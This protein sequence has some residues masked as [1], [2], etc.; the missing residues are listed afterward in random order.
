MSRIAKVKKCFDNREQISF[1]NQQYIN[2]VEH[3]FQKALEQDLQEGDISQVPA[4][5][6]KKETKADIIACTRGIVAGLEEIIHILNKN[7]LVVNSYFNDGN[8]IDNHEVLLSINGKISTILALE[9]TILNFLQRLCGIATQTKK[10]ADKI[11]HTDTYVIGTRKTIWGMWDK[12]A[13]QCGGGLSH[14]LGL[15]DAAMLKENH[16]KIL[17]ENHGF[18]AIKNSIEQTI[19]KNNPRFVEIEVSGAREFHKIAD[20]LANLNTSTPKVIM[21]DHFSPTKIKGCLAEAKDKNYYQKIFFEASGNITLDNIRDYAEAG[22]DV[23]SCGALTH[24]VKSLDLS[25]LF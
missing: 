2:L 20:L 5:L 4:K 22:V 25:M 18:Q 8:K 9:R 23:I 1:Q 13:V 11:A 6:Y 10:Y 19:K 7:D 16:L 24:S 17:K 14:R 12:K 21:F 3:T 15:F